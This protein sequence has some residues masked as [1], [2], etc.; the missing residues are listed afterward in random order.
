MTRTI[1]RRKIAPRPPAEEYAEDLE[2]ELELAAR[3]EPHELPLF[4]P[5]SRRHPVT[6][7]LDDEDL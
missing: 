5:Q 3:Y 6:E 7:S 2:F 1:A 4:G